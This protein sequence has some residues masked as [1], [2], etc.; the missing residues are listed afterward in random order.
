MEIGNTVRVND[1]S[2]QF[3]VENRPVAISIR[4]DLESGEDGE[5]TFLVKSFQRIHH[6]RPIALELG[7]S[8][9]VKIDYV[10]NSLVRLGH[11]WPMGMSCHGAEIQLLSSVFQSVFQRAVAV[12]KTAMIVQIAE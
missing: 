10:L 2:A 8:F 12:G 4:V 11:V 9:V 7:E 3:L 1:F 6:S 5:G